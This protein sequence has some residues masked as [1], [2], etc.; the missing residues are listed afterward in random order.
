MPL[1]LLVPAVIRAA[2]VKWAPPGASTTESTI[3][4][5]TSNACGGTALTS[6]S[7]E[8]TRSTDR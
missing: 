7:V 3:I 6:S 2:V 1:K 5:F 8:T 4:R